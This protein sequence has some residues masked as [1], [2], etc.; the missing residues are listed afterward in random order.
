MPFKDRT[1]IKYGKGDVAQ[2]RVFRNQITAINI[3]Y[4]S[5]H[6]YDDDNYSR[7]DRGRGM[8]PRY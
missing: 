2:L 1:N 7:D 6:D 8:R 5:I 4:G 3:G